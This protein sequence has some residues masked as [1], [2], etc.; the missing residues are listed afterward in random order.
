MNDKWQVMSDKR[1]HIQWASFLPLQSSRILR[2]TKSQEWAR[3][4]IVH[5]GGAR[6]F[7]RGACNPA[8][9][10]CFPFVASFV[11]TA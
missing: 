9:R 4:G 1:L 11:C 6:K 5:C 2:F 7:P 10:S 8:A 3:I